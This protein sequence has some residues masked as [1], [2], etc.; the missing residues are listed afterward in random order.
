MNHSETLARLLAE[1]DQRA[2]QQ[3]LQIRAREQE[4]IKR[5]EAETE[6][7]LNTELA[8]RE[9]KFRHDLDARQKK[10]L[11]RANE[12]R[13]ARIWAFERGKIQELEFAIRRRLESQSFDA[14]R[15][16]RWLESAQ[17]KIGRTKRVVLEVRK[18]WLVAVHK[19]GIRV[20]ERSMLGGAILTDQETG[21]QVDGSWDRRLADLR[22]VIWQQ[23]KSDVGQNH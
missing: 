17:K 16:E 1:I 8:R 11:R 12:A 22:S 23:W 21:R 5:I 15:F 20:K 18:D 10:M 9:E 13:L 2:K 6:A 3:M 14:S 19:Y 7:E 4:S